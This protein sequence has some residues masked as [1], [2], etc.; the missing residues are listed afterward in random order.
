MATRMRQAWAGR[1][2]LAGLLLP[3]LLALACVPAGARAGQAPP[4]GRCYLI[5]TDVEVD[6]VRAVAMLARTGRVAAVVVTEG[7][8]RIP[9]GV[10]ALQ[11]MLRRGGQADI[12]VLHGASPNPKWPERLDPGELG[13]WRDNAERL[14]RL[15]DAPVPAA[16]P[17]TADIAAALRPHLAGCHR[18]SLLVIG[19]WTSFLRYAAEVLERVDRIAAQGRPYP[20]ELSGQPDG[21]NCRY[22]LDSCFAAFDLLAGRQQR[23]D[24]RVR[25]DWV[26]IPGGL[27]A[28]GRA[29]PGVDEHGTRLYAFRPDANWIAA[30][31]HA[32]DGMAPV[33]AA[34]LRA[35]P[36]GWER[37]SLW[38]DL[39]AL[40]LL[41]PDVFAARGG[42]MEPC[43]P[44]ATVRRLLTEA[45]AVDPPHWAARPRTA[46]A[47]SA[48]P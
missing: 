20:D 14:N 26:D 16:D 21:F 41:R 4:D 25:T 27:E 10:G 9:R 17:P 31:E 28:C 45:L 29:E 36:G 6:D 42:H 47:R 2:R 19:P 33:V 11:E 44:A 18:V 5:D 39:A 46:E 35:H 15:L 8:F 32:K 7:I 34:V 37:T 30:L 48:G 22:D 13:R 43:V 3:V 38:D 24:R 12:P 23:A 40:Y 1:R